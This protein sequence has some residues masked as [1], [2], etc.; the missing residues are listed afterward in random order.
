MTKAY[1]LI[2]TTT[3]TNR[4]VIARLKELKGVAGVDMVTGPFDVVAIVEATSLAEV[5]E[6]VTAR[7]HPIPGITRT[8]TC[9]VM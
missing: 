2:E 9:L 3:G 7:I 1:V 8:V 6:V 4:D 5:G